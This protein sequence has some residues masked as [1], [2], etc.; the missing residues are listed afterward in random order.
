MGPL[1]EMSHVIRFKKRMTTNLDVVITA[2]DNDSFVCSRRHLP[3]LLLG[4]PYA[5][6]S[7]SRGAP[8]YSHIL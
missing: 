7:P 6:L 1:N 5:S 4:E 8:M 3:L 2:A